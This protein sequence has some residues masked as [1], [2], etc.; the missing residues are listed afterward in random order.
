MN[1]EQRSHGDGESDHSDT[2]SRRQFL[3]YMS[4]GAL[5]GTA[6]VG[7]DQAIGAADSTQE[8]LTSFPEGSRRT[9]DVFVHEG[10]AGYEAINADGE[11][12]NSGSD[13]WTVLENGIDAV[14]DGG[15][16]HVN[17]Q[18]RSTSTIEIR[19]SIKMYGSEAF[20]DHQPSGDFVFRFKGNERHVT[21]LTEAAKTGDHT[22]TLDDTS[23]L[24]K[25]DLL[26]LEETDGE[27]VL[28]L[29]E[30][31][32]EPHSVLEVDGSTVKLEDTIVW[33]DNYPPGTRV[34]VINP[35]EVHVS[36]FNLQA[37][38][39][40]GN[41]FGVYAHMCRDSTFENL[42]LVKF[43]NRAM[44]LEACA[45]FRVR[46][47]TVLQSAAVHLG[48]AYGIMV[49]AGCHDILIE[50][51]VA[52]ECRHALSVTNGGPREVA[53]RAVKIRDCFV[54]SVG[55][56]AINCHGGSAHDV[57]VEGCTVHPEPDMPG[58]RTGAQKTVV[59]GCEFRMDGHSA[60]D[61]RND[62]Q[63]MVISVTDS[64]VFGASGAVHLDGEE[65]YEF[66]P[67]WKLVHIDNVRAYGCKMFF[68]L[69]PGA[70][71]RVRDL[72]IRGCYWDEVTREGL[73]FANQVDGG[74]IEGND[75]GNAP[76]ESHVVV[77]DN[78]DSKV[79]DLHIVDNRFQQ[80]TGTNAFIR[81]SHCRNCV[82]SDNKFES[83]SDVNI[84]EDNTN[85]T[86]NLIKENT[87][88]APNPS[89]DPI[90]EDDGSIAKNNYVYDT[91][92]RS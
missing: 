37:P 77:R 30:P 59:S 3:K 6:V 88:F 36:G 81:L 71:D 49:W 31:P 75:F 62:G 29:N 4:A 66:N 27:P 34:Y 72:V 57:R 8:S 18:Y 68:E 61:T 51:C 58:L 55:S 60:V 19:K 74:I 43:G 79:N 90:A 50:G 78:S 13:G 48:K 52:K 89:D 69:D 44:V 56:A 15:S 46:D 21:T 65:K 85:S 11:T 83:G 26:L 64:D 28:G 9:H 67:L 32:G 10:N 20:I 25:G 7:I 63:E 2:N 73:R 14:P 45:N 82:V 39:K 47:S 87:Y 33:R 24:E 80:P 41:Y 70:L 76:S 86:A 84:Y 23:G 1:D 12:I 91:N 92:N 16:I 53:S 38:A 54:S 22:V 40:D 5:G 17:G 35:I 42:R